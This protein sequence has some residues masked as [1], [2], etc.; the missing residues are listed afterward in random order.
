MTHTS[1][2]KDRIE[3]DTAGSRQRHPQ[4]VVQ[5]PM[6]GISMPNRQAGEPPRTE[7]I[8]MKTELRIAANV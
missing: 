8:S 2:F 1:L 5:A 7:S 6:A 4:G 3:A